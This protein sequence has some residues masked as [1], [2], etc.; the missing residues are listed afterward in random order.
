MS[1]GTIFIISGPSG[2]GKS[3]IIDSILEA[4]PDTFFSVSATTRGPRPGEVDGKDYNFVSK[5]DFEEMIKK[6]ELLEYAEY[7]GNF[8]GTPSR[9]VFDNIEKGHDVIIEVEVKGHSQLREKL[10]EAVSIFISPP[11]I[12][13]LEERLR[14]RSTE[15]E[16]KIQSRIATARHEMQFADSYDYVVV[17]NELDAAVRDALAIISKNHFSGGKQL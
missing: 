4:Y 5:A 2:T 13:I 12:E 7:V 10:P 14:S 6:G 17:N 1:K 15:T 16:E 9:P 3:T 11:S 8:Y